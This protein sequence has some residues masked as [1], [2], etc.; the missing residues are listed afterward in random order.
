[1]IALTIHELLCKELTNHGQQRKGNLVE[2]FVTLKTQ[3]YLE[4]SG[5]KRS[6]SLFCW[7]NSESSEHTGEGQAA[8]TTQ[9]QG[10]GEKDRLEGHLKSNISLWGVRE[11]GNKCGA[12]SRGRS[13]C[14]RPKCSQLVS[15]YTFG[16]LPCN[17]E[18]LG[19]G[20]W[21]FIGI[22]IFLTYYSLANWNLRKIAHEGIQNEMPPSQVEFSPPFF[23]LFPAG[24]WVWRWLLFP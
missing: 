19:G 20:I 11:T 4:D 10:S 7:Q 5:S 13:N 16:E 2:R 9:A 21:V 14:L 22:W 17:F 18:F 8:I 15:I 1:M 6:F 23:Q 3:F 12:E 24:T